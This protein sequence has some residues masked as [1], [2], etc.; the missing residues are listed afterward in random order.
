VLLRRRLQGICGGYL[1]LTF[2][3]IAAS[4]LVMA[5]VASGVERFAAGPVPGTGSLAQA[6][7]LFLAIGSGLVALAAAAKLLHIREFDDVVAGAKARLM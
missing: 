6:V 7:R 2:G 3:K 5:A 1:A 4:A